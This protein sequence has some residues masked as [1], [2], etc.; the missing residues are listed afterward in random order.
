[1]QGKQIA[2]AALVLFVSLFPSLSPLHTDMFQLSAQKEASYEAMTG[3]F[4]PLQ[5]ENRQLT[6]KLE[7]ARV[8]LA[9]LGLLTG[10]H[11]IP[12][13]TRIIQAAGHTSMRGTRVE[14]N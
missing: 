5:S 13:Q 14:G 11:T 7:T 9:G 4:I 1:V 6:G 3:Q 10:T 2:P 8:R 12:S